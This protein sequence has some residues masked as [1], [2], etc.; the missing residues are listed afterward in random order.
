MEAIKFKSL[1]ADPELKLL[2]A[3]EKAQEKIIVDAEH[4][5]SG[6]VAA[7]TSVLVVTER[8]LEGLDKGS[9]RFLGGSKMINARQLASDTCLDVKV[10][11]YQHYYC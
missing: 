7:V 10:C 9:S 4:I 11:D 3:N 8:V 5:Y 2:Y 6:I 1:E